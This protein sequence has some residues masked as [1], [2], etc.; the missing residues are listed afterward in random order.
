M[1]GHESIPVAAM[2]ASDGTSISWFLCTCG[3]S[4][5][6]DIATHLLEVA[7]V[8]LLFRSRMTRS[9]S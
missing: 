6:G 9:A 1:D 8:D 2:S 5:D 4:G 3:T 7:E